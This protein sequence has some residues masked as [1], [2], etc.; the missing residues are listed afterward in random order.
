MCIRDRVNIKH[1]ANSIRTH[2]AGIMSTAVNYTYQYLCSKLHLF[3]QFLYDEQVKSRLLK[4][5]LFFKEQQSNTKYPYDRADRFARGMRKL[6]I[7]EDGSTYLDQ[8]RVLITHTGNALGYVRLIRSGGLRYFSNAVSF[9][10]NL[11]HIV[12]FESLY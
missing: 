4:E 9:V 8:F 10:P 3:S 1:T 6:G 5:V 2:G 12:N 7:K 11:K